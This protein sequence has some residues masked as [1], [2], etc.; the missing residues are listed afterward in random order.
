M[1]QPATATRPAT[2]TCQVLIVE[3]EYVIANDLRLLLLEAGY[4][5]LGLADS[6][7]EARLLLSQHRPD[8]V[9]L[10]IYLKGS[11]TGLD[12]APAL[13][14]AGIPFIYL[15]ANDSPSVLEAVKATQPSGYV[16]K[17][18]REKDVLTALEIGRYRHAHSVEVRLREEK[19]LQITLTEALAAQIPWPDK[20]LQLARLFQEPI[21]FDSLRVRYQDEHNYLSYCFYRTGFDEYQVLDD[22]AFLRLTNQPV[23][24]LPQLRAQPPAF[25]LMPGCYNGEAFTQWARQH[26]MLQVISKTLRMAS[27]LVMPISLGPAPRFVLSFFSRRPDAYRTRHLALLDRLAQ[28][29]ALTLERALA[30]EEIARLSEQLRQENS[31]LQEEVKTTANFEEIIGTS[32]CLL[33]VFNQVSQVAPTDSTVLLLG[34][35]GTGKELFARALHNLSGRRDKLLVKVN[36]AALPAALIESELFGHEKGAFTGAVD[37]RI[38]KF[39][40]AKGGTIFLD[41]I[42]ELPLELQAKLLRVLQEKEIERLGGNGPIKTDVRVLVATNRELEK[43]VSAGR[44][45]MDLYFRLAVFPL[46]LPSLRERPDDLPALANFFG[47]RAARK[48]GR[49]FKGLSDNMLQEMRAYSWPGNIRELENVIEQAVILSDGQQPLALGRS[50]AT[51]LFDGGAAPASVAPVGAPSAPPPRDLLAVKQLQQE[52]EREYILS[53]LVKSNGRVRGSG[54]A[55]ELLN[56]KPTTLE[57]RMEKLGIRK[58]ITTAGPES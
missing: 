23:S 45:R 22:E 17:P 36:C 28:P 33:R 44:F 41:E 42:G 53:V 7:A 14:E 16:V 12:L 10:D 48:L 21:G 37:R 19:T 30:F 3:D 27:A 52:T 47:Q 25:Y 5:V 49:L 20:L 34:E 1:H 15:S 56:L 39:E 31:Y 8:V 50:L 38:G 24:L 57:Y 18:F 4:G 2:T 54:G 40:L 32:P 26:P 9:L 11:E 46:T 51:P 13:E 55:A 58:T 35:S 29:V 43:E 6:V